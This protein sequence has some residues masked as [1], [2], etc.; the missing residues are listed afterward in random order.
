MIIPH[1]RYSPFERSR[2]PGVTGIHITTGNTNQWS[3]EIVKECTVKGKS[4]TVI[5]VCHTNARY[6]RQNLTQLNPIDVMA[7]LT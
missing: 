7:I 6:C 2:V 4:I 3:T 1:Q 5:N